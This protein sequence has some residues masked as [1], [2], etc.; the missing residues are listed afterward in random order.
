MNLT[1]RQ[2]EVLDYIKRFIASRGYSPTVR[3]IA[4]GLGFKSPSSVQDHLKRLVS[5]GVI[6]IDRNKSRTIE[7]LV[8]NEYIKTA[9]S[10][11]SIAVLND[12]DNSVIREFM[13]IPIFMLNNYA[14]KN[15]Y[16]YKKGSSIYVVNAGLKLKNRPSLVT[17]NGKFVVDE[18]AEEDIFGNIVSKFVVY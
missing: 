3:E 5:S 1:S 14:P 9:E 12:K 17:K 10:V 7:L 18:F 6:T 15:L 4:A 16:V 11:T 13:E 8:Q 2:F